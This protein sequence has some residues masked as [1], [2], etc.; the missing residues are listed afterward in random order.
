MREGILGLMVMG[1]ARSGFGGGCFSALPDLAPPDLAAAIP[2]PTVTQNWSILG[3]IQI[4][5]TKL[6]I[7]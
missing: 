1:A 7:T 5:K 6:S 2:P 4:N 3:L